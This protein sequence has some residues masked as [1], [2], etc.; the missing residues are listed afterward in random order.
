MWTPL[1]AVFLAIGVVN[2]PGM[3]QAEQEYLQREPVI[4]VQDI[5]TTQVYI[6][7]FDRLVL[8]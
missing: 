1:A 4:E 2:T 3:I 7:Q 5:Q 6:D 8:E